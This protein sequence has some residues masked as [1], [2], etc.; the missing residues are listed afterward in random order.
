MQKQTTLLFLLLALSATLFGQQD[1]Q[2]ANTSISIREVPAIQLPALD[3][4]QLLADELAQ[5]APGRAPHFAQTITVDISPATHG[6]WEES[7]GMAV[8]RLRVPSPGARS[9]NFGFD[10][11]IMPA[12]GRLMLYTPDHKDIQGPFTPAD[13]EEHEELWTPTIDGD[14]IVIEVSLPIEQRNQLRL[15][16]KS[17]NHDFLGFKSLTGLLS[18]SCNLDVVCG[19]ED[20]WGIVD[21]YRD[22]IQSV[23][24]MSLNGNTFCTGF[25][26]NNARQDCTPFFITANH[27]GVGNG[28]APSLVVYWNYV[29]SFCRQPGTP[30]SGSNG[31]GT[32]TD[33]NSGSIFRAAYGPSDMT[34]VELDD[35]VSSTADAWFAGWDASEVLAQDTIIGIHHPSNDEKRISFQ[36]DGVYRGSWGNSGT[37]VPNGNHLIIEDWDIGTTEGGSSGSPLFNSN[38]QV[39][40]QLHGGLA[41][42]GNNE[43]D[44]Y[45]WMAFSWEGGG[46]PAS[47]LKPWLDPDNTGILTIDGRAQ[48][49]CSFFALADRPVQSVCAEEVVSYSISTSENFVGSVNLSLDN[50]PDG[51]IAT[52]ADN[53]VSPGESTM[54]TIAGTENLSA[55]TYIFNLIGS[56]GSNTST[57]TLFLTIATGL[58]LTPGLSSPANMSV[59]QTLVV[60]L[61]WEE[62]DE[63]ISYSIELATDADFNDLI[64]QQAGLSDNTFITPTLAISTTYFWRVRAINVCGTGSWSAPFSF[65][66]GA[67]SCGL[68]P[69]NTDGITIGPGGGTTATSTLVINQE[70]PIS[71]IRLVNFT[72]DHTYTGDLAATL[73]APNGTSIQLFTQPDCFRPGMMVTFDDAATATYAQFNNTCDGGQTYAI[74][75]EFQPFEALSTFLG[76]SAIGTWTLTITD[77]F[78][79]DGGQLLGWGL[80]ICTLLPDMTTLTSSE[81]SI[82]SCINE[83]VSLDLT[84]GSGFE[85]NVNLSA[86]NLPFG[87]TVSF[88]ANN[89]APGS[90][91]NVTITGLSAAGTYD[92]AFSANDGTEMASSSVSLSLLQTPV[93]SAA[94][95]PL[96]GAVDVDI[97]TLLFMATVADAEFYL[98]TLSANPDLSDPILDAFPSVNTLIFP[99]NLAY[100]TTYYWTITPTNA[101]GPADD[102]T[103]YSFTTLPD[104]SI[105]NNQEQLAI[106]LSDGLQASFVLGEGLGNEP[107]IDVSTFPAADFSNFTQSFDSNTRELTLNWD[108]FAGIP[109]GPYQL[110]INVSGEGYFNSTASQLTIITSPALATLQSPA[111]QATIVGSNTVNF[112][113]TG[114]NN[115][116]DYTLEIAT[117]DNFTNIVFSNTTTALGLDVELATGQYFWRVIAANDCGESV[118]AFF[119][120]TF[121][122]TATIDIAGANLKIWPNPTNGPLQ[123]A[124]SHELSG[125]LDISLLAV[126]GQ[127]IRDYQLPA[128]A[129]IQ[130]LHLG[131]LPAGVYLLKVTNGANQSISRIMVE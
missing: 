65:Q 84:V 107:T 27:C 122:T 45:G 130:T 118:S 30:A 82:I 44:S 56:D 46:T 113:W 58:P 131:D 102:N 37:P 85:N 72:T 34:L 112:A 94:E 16:L 31:N 35:P 90:V 7:H 55:G 19:E 99:G 104:V 2:L 22:I 25:L 8:W 70:G 4:K 63:I 62:V 41:A 97:N 48:I 20:G 40:G 96:N 111:D 69:A 77:N 101:C 29:N 11:F 71:S 1:Q 50:L 59:D 123:L 33:F 121:E 32:F 24:N 68:T 78:N 3:N 52:F 39:I 127:R 88:E 12:G 26:V 64:T 10:Q 98:V 93:A 120:F 9:L 49:L 75:G 66:T 87:A 14:E 6:L 17:V 38:K 115:T 18:G 126:N 114:V 119:V 43:Y 79:D 108:S 60:V 36:W 103:V 81:S 23:A 129:G 105:Q 74:Q 95:A 13:N 100:N 109:A 116:E 15:H 57:Q 110:L 91:V 117:D 54:L 73:T 51:L 21:H 86:S 125:K 47:S 42:C 124:L 83:A 106:C 80:D 76:E 67:L 128:I 89:V 61:N 53:T 5:R 28:N 92:I